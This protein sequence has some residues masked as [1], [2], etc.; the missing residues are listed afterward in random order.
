MSGQQLLS[1]AAAL[2][3]TTLTGTSLVEQRDRGSITATVTDRTGAVVPGAQVT[4]LNTAMGATY[5]IVTVETTN[6]T[7][8]SPSSG[9]YKLTGSRTEFCDYVQTGVPAQAAVSPRI[10]SNRQCRTEF[11]FSLSADH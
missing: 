11:L 1:H 8:P 4:V 5:N 9:N 3:V 7:I 2:L 10:A 6:Y